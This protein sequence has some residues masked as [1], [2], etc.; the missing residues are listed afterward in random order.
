M[1]HPKVFPFLLATFLFSSPVPAQERPRA[2]TPAQAA[3][4]TNHFY[5]PGGRTELHRQ[6]LL[7]K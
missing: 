6:A 1:F 2:V 5:S 4:R 7:S 3:D